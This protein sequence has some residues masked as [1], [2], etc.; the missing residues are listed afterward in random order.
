[1]ETLICGDPAAMSRGMARTPRLHDYVDRT[2]L[3]CT[4][5]MC[6]G[7]RH[8]KMNSP[9]APTVTPHGEANKR[10][11]NDLIVGRHDART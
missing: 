6:F 8:R 3:L 11:I 9:F 7:W 4:S 10:S 2:M 5:R 1:M